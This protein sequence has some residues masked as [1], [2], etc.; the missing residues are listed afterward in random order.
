MSG[1]LHSRSCDLAYRLHGS[2]PRLLN[3]LCHLGEGTLIIR[4]Q[5]LSL[6][7]DTGF[8]LFVAREPGGWNV[9]RDAISGL[10]VDLGQAHQVHALADPDDAHPVFSINPPG[11]GIEL[12]VRL[13]RHDWKSRVV[14]EIVDVFQGVPIDARDRH[15][16]GA[17]AWLDEW[18]ST[19][20]RNRSIDWNVAAALDGC[21]C[22]EVEVKT[23]MHRVKAAFRPAFLDSEGPVLRIA[24]AG[25]KHVVFAD[26]AAPGFCWASLAPGHL[27]IQVAA[28][29]RIEAAVAAA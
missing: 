5:G 17:G 29:E 27:R 11:N 16:L 15:S 10:E 6:A 25:R 13:D 26:T 7:K 18:E 8:G 1:F 14:R 21:R 9:L 20:P 19:P 24:D 22:L 28:E 4:Q 12:S 2:T 23:A 3:Q